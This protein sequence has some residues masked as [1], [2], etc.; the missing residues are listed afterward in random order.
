MNMEH[1]G[2]WPRCAAVWLGASAVTVGT[3]GSLVNDVRRPLPDRFDQIVVRAAEW[4]V[5]A[6][7]VWLWAATSSVVYEAMRAPRTEPVGEA[8]FG[9]PVTLRRFVLTACG[10]AVVAGLAAPAVADGPPPTDLAHVPV[11]E[12]TSPVDPDRPRLPRRHGEVIVRAGDSLWRIASE[13]IGQR[14][15]DAQ[16]TTAWRRIYDANRAVI[17]GDPGLIRPGQKLSLPQEERHE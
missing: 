12:S 3:V 11:H 17:G 16:V 14:A 4:A 2:R 1:A 13:E 9:V 10:A 8:R 5:L 6:C 15:T 7:I